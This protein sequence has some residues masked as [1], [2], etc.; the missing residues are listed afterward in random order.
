MKGI[1]FIKEKRI[2]NIFPL[3]KGWSRDEKYILTDCFGERFLLRITATEKEDRAIRQ[4]SFLRELQNL[5]INCPK[6]LEYGKT[7]DARIYT[8][9]SFLP[10]EDGETA[11]AMLSKEKGY[12]LGKEGGEILR[13]IHSLPISEEIGSWWERYK[14]K[15]QRKVD[16]LKNCPLKIPNQ[17]RIIEYYLDNAKLMQ[18][19]PMV[20]THGDY[21][22]GNMVVDNGRLGVIDFEKCN[23]A[24]PYDDFKPYCWNVFANSSFERGLIDG[25]FNGNIPKDFFKILKF[26]TAESL[27]SHLPWAMT[28]GEEEIKTSF[29]VADSAM[30]WWGNFELDVPTWY[31]D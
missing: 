24:D 2:T 4:Y 21:H 15:I 31:K 14:P 12:L 28:F 8:V 26:Y 9:L 30:Q 19:R 17:E 27:I 29:K 25:Y 16:A 1:N 3:N 22:L 13:K 10:G 23:Y 11:L 18:S 7:Q 20:L 5:K 6:A